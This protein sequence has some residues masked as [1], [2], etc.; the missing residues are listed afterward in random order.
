MPPSIPTNP[1]K[2]HPIHPNLRTSSRCPHFI[3]FA[4]DTGGHDQQ[5]D[6]DRLAQHLFG[7]VDSEAGNPRFRRDEA[8]DGN[9]I[10]E[11]TDLS[12]KNQLIQ[13]HILLSCTLDLSFC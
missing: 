7:P 3:G 5:Q 10:R 6:Q 11:L 8:K 13:L 12:P 2:A 1:A 9:L 4:A